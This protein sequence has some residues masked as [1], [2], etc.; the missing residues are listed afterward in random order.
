MTETLFGSLKVE[1][2]Y[3]M[4]FETRRQAQVE[5]IDWLAFYN[6]KKDA[7]DLGLYEPHGVRGKLASPTKGAGGIMQAL[8]EALHGGKVIATGRALPPSRTGLPPAGSRQLR[9]AHA[10]RL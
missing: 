9:L 4:R 5:V 2:L 3:D 8:W 10:N 1:R 6:R 7:F